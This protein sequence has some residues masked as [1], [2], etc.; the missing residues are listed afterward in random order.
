MPNT[1]FLEVGPGS[2]AIIE[3]LKHVDKAIVIDLKGAYSRKGSTIFLEQDAG[4]EKWRLS[5]NSVDGIVSNQCLEHI[6][7]TD[8]F[9]AEAHRVLRDYGVIVIS[10]PNQSALAF[11][12][13]MLLTF[14]PPPHE[15][16]I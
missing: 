14:T 7:N 12:F 3:K 6:P 10:V 1:V 2:D 11:I 16:S 15:F 9:L 13:L 4:E 8:H 5:D